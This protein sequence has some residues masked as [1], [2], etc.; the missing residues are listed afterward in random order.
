MRVCDA[1][2]DLALL[3]AQERAQHFITIYHAIWQV[4]IGLLC[5][6]RLPVP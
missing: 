1:P 5:I 6:V 3:P 4:A 2:A